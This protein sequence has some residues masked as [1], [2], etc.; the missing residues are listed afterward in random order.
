MTARGARDIVT[1]IKPSLRFVY[2]QFIWKTSMSGLRY[3]SR[4]ATAAEREGQAWR[5]PGLPPGAIKRVSAIER[6]AVVA[7]RVAIAALVDRPHALM[8]IAAEGAKRPEH[9]GVVI[10]FVRRMM[11][12][13]RRRRRPARFEA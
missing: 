12:R 8:T 3:L 4:P 9:E 2:C 10:A 13:D 7:D 11:I 6:V 5:G 1:A